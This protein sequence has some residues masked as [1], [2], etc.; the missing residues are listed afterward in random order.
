VNPQEP[1]TGQAWYDWYV[2]ATPNDPNQVY[3]GGIDSFRGTVSGSTAKWVNITTQG[4]N[5]IHPD[6]H[7]L[8][9]A[10]NDPQVIYAGCDGGIFRSANSGATW[11]ALNKGLGI[12]EI[13]YLAGDPNTWKW[14]MAG[15]QDNGTIRYTGSSSFD[16]DSIAGGDGGDCAVNQSNPLV[17]YHSYYDVSLERSAD[18][19]DTWTSLGLPWPPTLASLWYPPVEVFGSTVAIGAACFW[20]PEMVCSHGQ[21][22]LLVFPPMNFHLPCAI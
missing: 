5:S 15:T 2:A 16:W 3:I 11:A 8:T 9:F 1:W 13:E 6:Q 17:V 14:L 18:K 4:S 20:H 21:P 7:C 19:G 12:T 22:L 10:P